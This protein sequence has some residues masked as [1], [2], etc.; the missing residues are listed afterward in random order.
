MAFEKELQT[1]FIVAFN[2]VLREM[3]GDKKDGIVKNLKA[4]KELQYNLRSKK[5][6]IIMY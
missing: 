4:V 1:M 2:E 6:T 5:S 3:V